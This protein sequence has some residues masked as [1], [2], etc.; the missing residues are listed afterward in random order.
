MHIKVFL[1]FPGAFFIL[2]S[3]HLLFLP[4]SHLQAFSLVLVGIFF[5][6]TAF[7]IVLFICFYIPSFFDSISLLRCLVFSHSLI[8]PVVFTMFF[9]FS[10][11]SFRLRNFA[12]RVLYDQG[13]RKK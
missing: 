10:I 11:V 7:W 13:L 5:T 8:P 4:R 2:F 6:I 12:S 1:E 9:P 3:Y